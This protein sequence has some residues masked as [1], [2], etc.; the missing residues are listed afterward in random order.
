ELRL[1]GVAQP[2]QDDVD[3]GAG[4]QEIESGRNRDVRTVIAPHAIDGYGGVHAR[5]RYAPAGRVLLALR[6]DDLLAAV[7][8]A[9]AD[10]VAQV[11][12]ARRRLDRERR[13][14]GGNNATVAG[15]AG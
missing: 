2:D 13:G 8:S 10:V 14:G 11:H 4:F 5:R 9:R 7:V 15:R 12:L 3:V 1:D 6:L